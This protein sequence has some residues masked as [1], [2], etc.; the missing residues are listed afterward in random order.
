MSKTQ[1]NTRLRRI[2]TVT[3]IILVGLA[4]FCG[5]S[6]HRSS[7]QFTDQSSNPGNLFKTGTITLT[8][9][10]SGQAVVTATGLMPGGSATGTLIIGVTGNYTANVTL[11][12]ATD[13]SALAQALTLRIEDVTGTATTLWTGTMSAFSTQ[14]LGTIASGASRSYR[15][16][17]TLPTTA[18]SSAMNG[19][20]TETLTF[21][22]VAQ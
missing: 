11:T 8:N 5:N 1:R 19:S 22:G 3:V 9:N 14:A 16:T 10:K 7:A 12:G 6:V 21:T 17:I 2:M 4:V 13:N 15:F 18:P 20:T